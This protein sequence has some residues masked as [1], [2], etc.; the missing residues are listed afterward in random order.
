MDQVI[1]T[2]SRAKNKVIE[3]YLPNNE[4]SHQ[5]MRNIRNVVFIKNHRASQTYVYK[6]FVSG[7]SIIYY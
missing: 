2:S 1:T 6:R 3:T 5:L 7:R 4:K